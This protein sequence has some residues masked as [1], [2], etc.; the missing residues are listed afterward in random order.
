M[1]IEVTTSNL[2]NAVAD[3][4]TRAV[5]AFDAGAEFLSEQIP[6]VVNQLLLWKMLESLV[7]LVL[8]SLFLVLLVWFNTKQWKWWATAPDG[9]HV[10]RINRDSG[11]LVLLNLVQIPIVLGTLSHFNLTWLYILVAPKVYL[12]EYATHLFK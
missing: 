1:S 5:A 2:E 3:L 12:I 10:A 11:I 9:C 4:I 8:A 6:D 7:P